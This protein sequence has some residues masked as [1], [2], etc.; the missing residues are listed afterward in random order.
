MRKGRFDEIFF[1]DLPNA[2]ERESVLAATLRTY[3]RDKVKIDL[4]KVAAAC[5]DFTGSE[6]AAIVPDALFAAFA[7]SAREITTADLI[8]A[9]TTVT[10]LA[11]TA[12]EKIDAL[13]NWA[14]GRARSASVSDSEGSSP[15]QATK[16][17]MVDL[18]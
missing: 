6:I 13:R 1:V 18:D 15:K 5:V 12:K 7:D 9:A 16:L 14:K 10:P 2:S 3:K 17:R 4:A 8:R 11:K